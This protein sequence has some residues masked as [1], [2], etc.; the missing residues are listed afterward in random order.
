M[1]DADWL[2]PAPIDQRNLFEGNSV[3]R[4]QQARV[5]ELQQ[6]PDRL[7]DVVFK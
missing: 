5:D 6:M 1:K 7:K 3:L 4:G 2:D